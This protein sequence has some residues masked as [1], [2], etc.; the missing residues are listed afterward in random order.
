MMTCYVLQPSEDSTAWSGTGTGQLV[1]SAAKLHH[2]VFFCVGFIL[3]ECHPCNTW[4]PG[5]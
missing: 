1:R 3:Q 5:A 4:R 2:D